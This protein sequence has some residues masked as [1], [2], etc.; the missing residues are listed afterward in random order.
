MNGPPDIAG[1]HS[2]VDFDRVVLRSNFNAKTTKH[3]PLSNICCISAHVIMNT[4]YPGVARHTNICT[5]KWKFSFEILRIPHMWYRH[6]SAVRQHST[7]KT[8]NGNLR[9]PTSSYRRDSVRMIKLCNRNRA[10][11]M[12]VREWKWMKKIVVQTAT[13]CVLI[14]A[15]RRRRRQHD[16][17]KIVQSE[18]IG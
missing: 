2:R 11:Q 7:H 1:K 12:G 13:A 5:I 4:T 16:K 15:A 6:A 18:H 14:R 17:C 9:I 8:Q 10:T 3:K